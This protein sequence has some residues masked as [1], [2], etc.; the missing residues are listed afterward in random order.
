MF[1]WLRPSRNFLSI[2]RLDLVEAARASSALPE[3]AQACAT[4]VC[5]PVLCAKTNMPDLL[6]VVAIFGSNP[7]AVPGTALRRAPPLAQTDP[8]F[9]DLWNPGLSCFFFF[10]NLSL[11][12]IF[13][14]LEP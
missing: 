13:S 12:Y 4:R 6:E 11:L 14:F 9:F 7:A 5:A 2:R 1:G 8:P 3:F 10:W